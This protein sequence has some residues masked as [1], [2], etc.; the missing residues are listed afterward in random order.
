MYDDQEDISTESYNDSYYLVEEPEG[1]M[2]DTTTTKPLPLRFK[3]VSE[4]KPVN[5]EPCKKMKELMK[6]F[7]GAK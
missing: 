3:P 2:V 1:E 4:Y 7:L 6:F 5:W